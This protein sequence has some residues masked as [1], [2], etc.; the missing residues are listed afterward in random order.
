MAR[1]PLCDDNWVMPESFS[2]TAPGPALSAGS[3]RRAAPARALRAL[4]VLMILAGGLALLDA[5]VTLLW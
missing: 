5:V 1:S 2:T 3:D 4:A